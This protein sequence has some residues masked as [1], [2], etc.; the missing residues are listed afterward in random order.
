[1]SSHEILHFWY[2]VYGIVTICSFFIWAIEIELC[3]LSWEQR[4][5]LKIV[6]V[7]QLRPSPV[8]PALPP[9]Q[10]KNPPTL[11]SSVLLF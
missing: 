8:T 3:C 5:A 6:N 11:P 2:N 10:K 9:P 4:Q 7:F 1:M